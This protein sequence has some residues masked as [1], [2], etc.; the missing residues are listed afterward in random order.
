MPVSADTILRIARTRP[1]DNG[2]APR[3]LGVDDWAWRRGRRYGTIL[4]D[5]ETNNVVDL[6]PD[7]E[8]DTL[9]EGL[10]DHPQAIW[11]SGGFCE[12]R[13]LCVRH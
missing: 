4:V 1:S 10:G 2:E 7:R 11:E 6:L 9:S 13:S 12:V 5:L 3:I 8:K